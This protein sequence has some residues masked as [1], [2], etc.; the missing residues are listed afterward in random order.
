MNSQTKLH[1]VA[2]GLVMYLKKKNLSSNEALS[3][4]KLTDK[5]IKNKEYSLAKDYE[6]RDATA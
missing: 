5:I 4:L 6:T 2:F 1:D 3:V